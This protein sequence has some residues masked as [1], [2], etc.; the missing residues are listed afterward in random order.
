MSASKDSVLDVPPPPPQHE[1]E[2]EQKQVP[3]LNASLRANVM[4]RGGKTRTLGHSLAAR[5]RERSRLKSKN[6]PNQSRTPK[7]KQI[8]F[9]RRNSRGTRLQSLAS[10]PPAEAK[11]TP[12]L[13]GFYGFDIDEEPLISHNNVPKTNKKEAPLTPIS[14]T[15]RIMSWNLA[16]I[17]NRIW[18]HV[19]HYTKEHDVILLQETLI[20]HP[21][22]L[23]VPPP[24]FRWIRQSDNSFKQGRGVAALVRSD[25]PIR[26][27]PQFSDSELMCLSLKEDLVII[28]GYNRP[29][30]TN[31]IEDLGKAFSKCR[32]RKIVALGDWNARHSEWDGVLSWSHIEGNALNRIIKQQGCEVLN[33]S[34]Q[35]TCV[36]AQGRS[37]ID[38]VIANARCISDPNA[39]NEAVTIAGGGS[40]HLP[41][42]WSIEAASATPDPKAL[43][44]VVTRRT[45]CQAAKATGNDLWEKWTATK[46]AWH[47]PTEAANWITEELRTIKESCTKEHTSYQ[48]MSRVPAWWSDS[49]EKLLLEQ[50]LAWSHFEK[51]VSDDDECG[52]R[53]WKKEISRLAR[54]IAAQTQKRIFKYWH[55]KCEAMSK[56]SHDSQRWQ[57]YRR[58]ARAS[59]TSLSPLH[60][61]DD[62]GKHQG[63]CSTD[64]DVAAVIADTM[65]ERHDA[66]KDEYEGPADRLDRVQLALFNHVHLAK[67]ALQANGTQYPASLPPE[68]VAVPE[69][70]LSKAIVQSS[71]TG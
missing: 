39:A 43:K 52:R 12:R 59:Q 36:R 71:G 67:K 58:A 24:M 33:K 57:E 1:T 30:R 11:I 32:D 7:Q 2:T 66:T 64:E 40:D 22:S 54:V 14:T 28:S 68:V 25:L 62:E 63:S 47:S 65:A 21:K 3:V 55:R 6:R 34:G 19:V 45:D 37:T 13:T 60:L 4:P 26:K 18:A 31:V 15:L 5:H 8:P 23:P 49:I 48:C 41:I 10:N 46:H 9:P 44:K 69:K 50:R 42:A 20:T 35:P 17:K 51:A 61:Y 53:T 27:L 16:G 70:H 56:M 38:L 29:K